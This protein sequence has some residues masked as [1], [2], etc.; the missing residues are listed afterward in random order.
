MVVRS[1]KDF[2]VAGCEGGYIYLWKDGLIVSWTQIHSATIRSILVHNDCIY[3]GGMDG[4]IMI[5]NV[6]FNDQEICL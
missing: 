6:A 4:T 3:S 5:S 2:I 1:F